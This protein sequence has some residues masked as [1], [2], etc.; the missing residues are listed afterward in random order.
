M[1]VPSAAASRFGAL[2]VAAVRVGKKVRYFIAFGDLIRV[3][4]YV[5]VCRRLPLHECPYLPFTG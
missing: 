4:A 5:S 3:V 2:G 1:P